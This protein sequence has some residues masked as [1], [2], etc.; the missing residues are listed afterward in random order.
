MRTLIA[1]LVLASTV[2]A[3]RTIRTGE[4]LGGAKSVKAIIRV[5]AVDVRLK[6]TQDSD[7]AF[8]L[9]YNYSN[10]ER[11]PKL[12]YEVE[13]DQG[14]FKLSNGK[15]HTNFPFLGFDK[16]KDSIDLELANSV[17]VS[18]DMGF[19]VCDARVDLGGM[20]ISDANFSTGVCSF[21]LNFSRPNKIE[22]SNIVVKTGIS[23]VTVENLS[24]AHAKSIE[25]NGGLGSMKID[26][27]GQLVTDCDVRIKTGL[28]SVDI[29]VPSDINTT[30]TTPESF[31]TSVDV[32]GFYSQGGGVYR[33]SENKGP[34][35]RIY[36]DSSM[37][38]VKIKSY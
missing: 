28:G 30:I 33:S 9:Y 14:I 16:D 2:F 19:G 25:V 12:L 26:F 13:G 23:S 35:L 18:L 10:E 5:G 4:D 38:G 29:S 24:N 20:Q 8:R 6:S 17:P 34:K 37:G 1:I 11:V 32:A 7:K 31:L 22:C 36:I 21:D 27:G 15:E 3:Q